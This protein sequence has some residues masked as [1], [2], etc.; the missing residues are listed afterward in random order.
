MTSSLRG[1]LQLVLAVA[2]VALAAVGCGSITPG[3]TDA[4]GAPTTT[5]AVTI[6]SASPAPPARSATLDD[7]D[8]LQAAIDAD[9]SDAAAQR[10]LGF[11]LLQRVRETADPS[12]Y[13]SAEAAF[14]RAHKLAPDDSLVLVG[15]GTLELGK[16]DFATALAT[17][18]HA[19]DM[20]PRS[21]VAHAIAVDALVELGRYDEADEAAAAML[22]LGSDLT[23]LSRVSYLAELHGQLDVAVTA[24]RAA[25]KSVGVAPENLAFTHVQLGNLLVYS[26][27][28]E[29]AAEE[30][31]RA[32]EV[33]PGH[34]PALAAQGRLAVADGRLDEA[35]DLF[36]RAADVVP[37]P[38]YVIA[39]ADAQAAAGLD[40]DAA[41][42]VELARAEIQLFQAT[43][44]MVDLDLALFEADHGD[45]QRAL[46]FA[47]AAYEAT[48]N[49]R[50][51]DALA[52]ALHRLGRD[53]DAKGW[54]DEA[55]R[56]GSRDPLFRFHAGAI[57]AALGDDAGAR[58]NLELALSTDAGFSATHAAEARRVLA[59]LG[60]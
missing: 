12:L 10:D 50:A 23:T 27:D 39:L 49:V 53:D 58:S 60:D 8:R 19:I 29:G 3:S 46:R 56:L 1:G 30:D 37:L 21:A 35:I 42:S 28:P 7:I 22:A 32:L 18:R 55:L 36:Q 43:G 52:W 45:A 11:A 5:P 26:G 41:R 25:T 33:V 15:I 40:D 59:A 31:E 13:A 51:A 17:A 9:P 16:H 14:N 47:E 4:T 6:P 24:M 57:A 2:A 38:E 54:S 34:A 48:P 44:V 20:A